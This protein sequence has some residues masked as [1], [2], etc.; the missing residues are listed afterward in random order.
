M[1]TDPALLSVHDLSVEFTTDN[2]PTVAVNSVDL[3]LHKGQTLGIVGESGSGK[4]VTSYAVLR[5]LEA[6]GRVTKGTVTFSGID[7]LGLGE[8]AMGDIRGREISMVFQNPRA[9]LNPTRTI[10]RQIGDVL[11]RHVQATRADARTKSIELLRAVR[12]AEPERRVDAYPFELSGGMCQRVV[13]A[14][15]LACR[16]QILIAD[17]PTTGLD[18]TTQKVIMDLIVELTRERQMS[19]ILITHDLGLAATY[20]DT[21]TIMRAGRIVETAPAAEIFRAPKDPYTKRLMLA[22]PRPG[23][24]VRDLLPERRPEPEPIAAPTQRQNLLSV[25]NLTKDYVSTRGETRRAVDRV[26]F[27]VR[28]GESIGLV[29]ESGSGKSTTASMIARLLDRTSGAIMFEE[30]DIAGIAPDTF[31]ADPARARLQLVFQDATDSLNP[32]LNALQ[33]I[34]EPLIRLGGARSTAAARPRV[35]ELADLVGLP[36]NLLDRLPHQ[37]SGGQKARVGIARAIALNPK[38][39]ILD[40]PTAA[41]DVS[42]Q[43]IVL[44]LL[45]DLKTTLG[46]SYLFVSHDLHVVRMMCERVLVMRHGRIVEEGDTETVM[47]APTHDYT[48][49]LLAALPQEID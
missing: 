48:K 3:S 1:S 14:I 42:V 13:I 35:K 18:V 15:A 44:N 12:I 43:A 24:S 21:I 9:A 32:R 26:N 4:S 25:V 39:L 17:E 2:G 38:L 37:L 29:G 28:A 49:E 41:L 47:R 8:N 11:I 6:A 45:T 22:T 46:M 33:A 40:E 20:C 34:A 27:D 36:Q 10:G 31:A 5:L 7:L 19:T 16:P 30:R 23:R